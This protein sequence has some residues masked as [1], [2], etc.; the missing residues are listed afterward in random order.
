MIYPHFRVTTVTHEGLVSVD[1]FESGD[2]EN[3]AL[4]TFNKARYET[5]G[6]LFVVV[7]KR[8][9]RGAEWSPVPGVAYTWSGAGR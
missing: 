2:N 8:S 4:R 7:L 9:E 3:R 6:T 5:P 1:D